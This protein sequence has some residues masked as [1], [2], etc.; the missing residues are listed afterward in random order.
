MR[1]SKQCRRWG[2]EKTDDTC[3]RRAG[4]WGW[5]C[6]EEQVTEPGPAQVEGQPCP[7]AH[8]N[9]QLPLSPT[10]RPGFPPAADADATGRAPCGTSTAGQSAEGLSEASPGRAQRGRP[11]TSLPAHARLCFGAQG[12]HYPAPYFVATSSQGTPIPGEPVLPTV[13]LVPSGAPLH[14]RN[15]T[16][17]LSPPSPGGHLNPLRG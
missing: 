14:N 12:S 10:R 9:P 2:W 8:G 15:G 5:A 7:C 17:E 13:C 3:V 16:R 4:G 1:D 11:A 6:W